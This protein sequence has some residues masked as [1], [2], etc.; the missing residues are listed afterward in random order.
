MDILQRETIARMVSKSWTSPTLLAK[1]KKPVKIKDLKLHLR[2]LWENVKQRT[3]LRKTF[4]QHE[5]L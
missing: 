4:A 2:K 1:K 3:S 5:K